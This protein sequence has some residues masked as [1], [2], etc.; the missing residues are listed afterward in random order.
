MRIGGSG[1]ELLLVGLAFTVCLIVL[2]QR[3]RP[4]Y[5]FAFTVSIMALIGMSADLLTQRVRDSVNGAALLLGVGLT[6]FMPF[7]QPTHASP[8]PIYTNLTH[9]QPYQS[10]L[11]VP[12]NKLL[13]GDYA[14]ELANYLQYRTDPGSAVALSFQTVDYSVLNE[15]DR[16]QPLEDFATQRGFTAIF[17]QPRIMAELRTVPALG[18]LCAAPVEITVLT[19]FCVTCVPR[20]GFS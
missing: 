10:L 3:P 8:R 2:T 4:S 17:V 20:A 5:L 6:L 15:W 11:A 1:R 16:R 18:A 7:Y 19:P 14:G 12:G 13:I 9:L